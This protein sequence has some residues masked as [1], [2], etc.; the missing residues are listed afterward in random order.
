MAEDIIVNLPTY[1]QV[2]KIEATSGVVMG[3]DGNKYLARFDEH[4]ETFEV[5]MDNNIN[6]QIFLESFKSKIVPSNQDWL[7]E[8][9][10]FPMLFLKD[11][12]RLTY[13]VKSDGGTTK[14]WFAIVD[15]NTFEVLGGK[16][17][18][19]EPLG[20]VIYNTSAM[21]DYC[22]DNNNNLWIRL[23][24]GSNMAVALIDLE[25]YEFKKYHTLKNN[26]TFSNVVGVGVTDDGCFGIATSTPPMLY[27]YSL[28]LDANGIPTGDGAS[29]AAQSLTAGGT[30]GQTAAGLVCDGEFFYTITTPSGTQAKRSKYKFNKYGNTFTEV[31]SFIT[32]GVPNPIVACSI[33]FFDTLEDGRRILVTIHGNGQN[34]LSC[35][36]VTLLD[37]FTNRYSA[38]LNTVTGSPLFHNGKIYYAGTDGTT[39]IRIGL[40]EYIPMIESYINKSTGNAN[41]RLIYMLANPA[42]SSSSVPTPSM[43]PNVTGIVNDN[44]IFLS[45]GNK[46]FRDVRRVFNL[47]N[48]IKEE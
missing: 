47:I 22:V 41:G 19:E 3:A 9:M 44:G 21:V 42:S 45:N 27:V 1:E 36:F 25:T 32:S 14:L 7:I 6:N 5:N 31:S 16:F 40:S 35:I 48:Y 4:Y 12:L 33:Y 38:S 10:S 28:N 29:E 15:A 43:T 18:T 34:G 26:G 23:V 37:T 24:R 17:V 30:Q 11:N 2:A 46:R 8:G 13:G 20:I 39:A